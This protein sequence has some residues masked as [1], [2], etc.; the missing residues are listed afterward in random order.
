MMVAML[1]TMPHGPNKLYV[2]C[3]PT[4]PAHVLAHELSTAMRPGPQIQAIRP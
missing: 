2:V 4:F 3:E 1:R